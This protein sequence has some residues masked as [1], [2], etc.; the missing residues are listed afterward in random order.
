[1]VSDFFQN[2][3]DDDRDFSDEFKL[4][5]EK[6]Q[7]LVYVPPKS[8]TELMRMTKLERLNYWKDTCPRNWWVENRD[9]FP[10]MSQA[11]LIIFDLVVSSAQSEREHS[12]L[13]L[14]L[15]PQRRSLSPELIRYI[16]LIHQNLPFFYPELF[17]D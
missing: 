4:Y 7:E 10:K 14:L 15:R 3:I 2:I 1:M 11:V 13:K 5:L 6:V 16:R 9:L 8:T 12:G 17:E